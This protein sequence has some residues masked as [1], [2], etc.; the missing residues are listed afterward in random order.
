MPKS[1]TKSIC[2]RCRFFRN[3]PEYLEAEYPGLATLGSAYGSVRSD[4]GICLKNDLYLSA[5]RWCA[6]FS[7]AEA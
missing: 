5:N 1:E 2:L 7:R 4:D 6:Q 3:A